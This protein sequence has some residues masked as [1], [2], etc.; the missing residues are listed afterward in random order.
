[1]IHSMI[2]RF[3]LRIVEAMNGQ[4]EKKCNVLKK[5]LWRIKK[6]EYK[7][8]I[9]SNDSFVTQTMPYF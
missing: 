7:T 6:L 8:I 4:S 1:M 5:N 3:P 2:E 9:F